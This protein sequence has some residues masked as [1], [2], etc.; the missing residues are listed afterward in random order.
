MVEDVFGVVVTA[1]RDG[2]SK[3]VDGKNARRPLTWPFRV[4]LLYWD[5]EPHR[6]HGVRHDGKEIKMK[7]NKKRQTEKNK[8]S[9]AVNKR[10]GRKK[11]E[12]LAHSR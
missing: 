5:L 3:D 11:K 9:N 4:P 7:T 12:R 2:A 8:H 1:D 10:N 6:Q